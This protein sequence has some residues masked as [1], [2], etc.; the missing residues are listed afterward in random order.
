MESP[1]KFPVTNALFRT[2]REYCE[3]E[4]IKDFDRLQNII[5]TGGAANFSRFSRPFWRD[6]QV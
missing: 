5:I 4:E 1:P 6:G 2:I 3:D